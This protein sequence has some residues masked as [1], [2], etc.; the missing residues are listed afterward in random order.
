MEESG[1]IGLD[2]LIESEK[3]G[4]FKVRTNKPFYNEIKR[5]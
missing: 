4:F 2:N 1:S 3:E 5:V